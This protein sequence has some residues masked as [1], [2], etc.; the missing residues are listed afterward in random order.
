M[1]RVTDFVEQSYAT[2]YHTVFRCVE[3]GQIS[4]FDPLPCKIRC[5]SGPGAPVRK[6]KY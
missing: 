4:G 6:P 3:E 1:K 2:D 5:R